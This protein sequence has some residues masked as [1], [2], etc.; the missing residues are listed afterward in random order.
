M[1]STGLKRYNPYQNNG[2]RTIGNMA[3]IGYQAAKRF[4]GNAPTRKPSGKGI[5]SKGRP[6]YGGS[7]TKTKRKRN[8]QKS[9][10]R[11]GN[12]IAY[13][14][15]TITYKKGKKFK[16]TEMLTANSINANLFS[17]GK[18]GV[19]GIQES[20][21]VAGVSC[22]ELVRFYETL[23]NGVGTVPTNRAISF[24]LKKITYDLEF[25]NCGPATIE[26]DIYFL[27]DKCTSITLPGTPIIEWTQGLQ[28]QQGP[29]VL[30]PLITTPWQKPTGI[31]RFNLLWWTKTFNKS[32]SPGEKIKLSVH[33]NVNRV[34]DY[35]YLQRFLT[36][37]GITSQFMVV[38]RGTICDGN[39]DPVI[40]ANRQNLCRTKLIWLAKY[41]MQGSLLSTRTKMTTYTSSLP[42]V[43]VTPLYDQNEGP[44]A[45]QNTED[46]TE[47][48]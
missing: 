10:D 15:H 19:Q 38:Q 28:D 11:D 40:T 41:S 47:Y 22:T 5:R 9:W 8:S 44:G 48:A 23:N 35:E 30:A 12:G 34:L 36:I 1:P 29:V 32:L 4:R 43:A 26:I 3:A 39:N 17:G 45:P 37:R 14:N 7:R 31:K 18:A 42:A 2:Y 46:G 33:H 16:L 6:R 27:I 21:I 20:A 13:K 25:S 24:N